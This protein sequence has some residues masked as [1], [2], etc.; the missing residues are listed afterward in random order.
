MLQ[1]ESRE[2]TVVL[3]RLCVIYP[4]GRRSTATDIELAAENVRKQEFK[5]RQMND[6]GNV[7]FD[8]RPTAHLDT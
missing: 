6:G 1:W 4:D 7:I 5:L 3:E 2:A 8:D